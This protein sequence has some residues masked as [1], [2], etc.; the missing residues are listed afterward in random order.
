MS[1]LSKLPTGQDRNVSWYVR[2]VVLR[3]SVFRSETITSY[4]AY[5]SLLSDESESIEDDR[6]MQEAIHASL[7]ETR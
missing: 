7:T 3:L 1:L 4:Q 6:Y 2:P 5:I